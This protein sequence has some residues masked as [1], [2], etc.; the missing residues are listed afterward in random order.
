ME[1]EKKNYAGYTMY[2]F[3]FGG[4][5]VLTLLAVGLTS[6]RLATPLMVGLIM[7]IALVQAVIVLFYNMHLKFHEKILIVFTAATFGLMIVL[8][9]GT[10]VDYIFPKI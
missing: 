9:F 5:M 10:L 3:T 6:V 2:L 4:L 7:C 8:I 1:Q